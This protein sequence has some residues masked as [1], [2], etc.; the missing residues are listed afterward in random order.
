MQ[1]TF[2]WVFGWLVVFTVAELA[3]VGFGLPRAILV[4]ALAGTA[5]GKALLIALY[6]MHLKFESP[7]VWILPGLPIF[8]IFF[9]IGGLFP[10]MVWH[11]TW[12]P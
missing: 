2:L 4:A 12:R 3:A 11:L 9:L 8:F 6:F 10:D 5:L 1:K 7:L